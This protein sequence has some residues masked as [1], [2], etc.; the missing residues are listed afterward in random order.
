[1]SQRWLS[2][3]QKQAGGLETIKSIAEAKDV[4]LLFVEDDEVHYQPDAAG[5]LHA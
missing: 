2:S 5:I 3:T 4:H 1:M